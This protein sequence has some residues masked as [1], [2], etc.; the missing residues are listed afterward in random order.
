MRLFRSLTIVLTFAVIFTLPERLLAAEAVN[1]WIATDCS[2]DTWDLDTFVASVTRKAKTPQEKAIAIFNYFQLTWFPYA[3]RAEYPFPVN[4]QSRM[5]DFIRM[6][7]VYG[8]ALCTQTNTMFAS[9]CKASGLFE[10]ARAISMP[11]HGTAEVKWGGKWHFMDAIVGAYALDKPGGEIVSIDQINANPV[12][13]SNAVKENRASVPFAPWSGAEIYPREALARFDIWYTYREYDIDFLVEGL[14]EYKPNP[15]EEPSTHTMAFTI[16]PGFRFTRMWDN[17]PDMYTVNT[18]YYRQEFN[19][20]RYSPSPAIRPPFMPAG[21]RT[22]LDTL[23]FK[24]YE[25]YKK[26]INGR[27]TYKYY[28][29]GIL[30]YHDDFSNRKIFAAADSIEGL[31]IRSSGDQA[32]DMLALADGAKDGAARLHFGSPY[33]FVGGSIRGSAQLA[34]G[35]WVAAYTT[36]P[37]GPAEV[38][39]GISESSGAFEFEIPADIISERY[40]LDITVRLYDG[41]GKGGANLRDL[42]VDG[43]VQLNMLTLPYLAPGS[44]KVSFRCAEFPAGAK[45]AVSYA[46]EEQGWLRRDEHIVSGQTDTW[47]INVA[48][49]RYPKMKAVTME[50]LF[51]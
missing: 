43:I 6:V 17:L 3:N 16:K 14:P 30:S 42:A 39:L 31:D 37:Y 25:P 2:V 38:L 48:G 28:A 19:N 41:S 9:T 1:P 47:P 50:Y 22:E 44:N 11:G 33:V 15:A 23:N 36:S 51:E 35:A 10:D 46:W 29:N 18:E 13:L 32:G 49:D 5:H 4:D 12:L 27:K 40:A 8:Y 45:F 7:N 24:I 34:Q 26:T 21:E 20:T